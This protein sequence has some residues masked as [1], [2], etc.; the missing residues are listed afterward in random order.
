M[1]A[2]PLRVCIV[3]PAY[4][5]G[6][7]VVEA[8]ES[9][10]AQDYPHIE[11]WV[12]DDGSTDDT[13]ATI[14]PYATRAHV[15]SQA[16]RGQSATI[17]HVWSETGADVVSYLS[18]D[19]R[20]EPG[21]VS[22]A[23]RVL[24]Q[25]PDAVLVYGD[26]NLIDPASAYVRHVQAPDP[27][28]ATMVRELVCAPG[29][30][31]FVRRSAAAR[32]EGWKPWLRQVP[33][34]EYWMRLG[35]LGRFIHWPHVL[36]S[37]RVHPGS[38]SFGEMS[39]E[40]ADEPIRVMADYF[41]NEAVPEAVRA[42]EP[43]AMSSAYVQA[44]RAHIRARRFGVAATRLRQA[45]RLDLANLWSRRSLRLLANAAVNQTGHRLLWWARRLR[46]G[47]A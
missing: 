13:A 7:F 5:H 18:A 20:L 3:I 39:M 41:A 14:A 15:I 17:N 42:L 40:R 16:N 21:A 37:L 24:E 34:L 47:G 9:V 8:I 22:A 33:D 6:A 29:P 11:L 32:I 27:D 44:A 28:Y 45:A 10:L 46:R 4:N 35:L 38:A 25:A 1:S 2:S 36:A 31:V 19:D 12:V 30:G 23:V 26:Y 43:R